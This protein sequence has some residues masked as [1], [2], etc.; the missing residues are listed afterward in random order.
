MSKAW[1]LTK[2]AAKVVGAVVLFSFA[3][4]AWGF[5]MAFICAAVTYNAFALT[6]LLEEV[7]AIRQQAYEMGL[8]GLRVE[9]D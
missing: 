8:T 2:M 6:K 1:F 7:R 4:E 5:G 9:P 3:A